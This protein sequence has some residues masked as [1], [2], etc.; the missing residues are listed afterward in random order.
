MKIYKLVWDDFCS[1]L[2]E[3][4]KPAYGSP[5]DNQTFTEVITLFEDNLKLLHPFM[6][7]VTE[8]IWQQITPR[9]PQEALIIASYPEQKPFDEGVLAEFELVQDII[10]GVRTV[11]KEKNIAFK[12]E[13][14][15]SVINNEQLPTHW[16]SLIQKLG[17]IPS[18]SYTDTAIEGAVSFRVKSNEYFIPILDKIN[19][20][21]ERK[22]LEKELAHIQG[23]LKSVRAKLSNERFVSSAPAPVIENERKK[24]ADALAKIETLEKSLQNL[25]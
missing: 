6:P 3:I 9:T 1:W 8:E 4:I 2:L 5:I 16:D 24:E 25:Q 14:S 21:E 7:F 12:D 10:S 18:I 23:F 11:R 19:V 17:N 13:I 15:L 20:E 22:K